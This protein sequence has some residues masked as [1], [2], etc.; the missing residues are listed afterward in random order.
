MK[1][2]H[3][4]IVNLFKTKTTIIITI[5]FLISLSGIVTCLF[6][7]EQNHFFRFSAPETIKKIDQ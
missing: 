5:N 4:E 2:V 7:F 6:S 3:E 1:N